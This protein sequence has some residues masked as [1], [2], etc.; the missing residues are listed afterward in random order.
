MRFRKQDGLRAK[1]PGRACTQSG[2]QRWEW[3]FDARRGSGTGIQHLF[4]NLGWSLGLFAC[5][6]FSQKGNEALP[7]VSSQWFNSTHMKS[8]VAGDA[9]VN[10]YQLDSTHLDK[11][12]VE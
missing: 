9:D 11:G 2:V 12:R 8:V 10:P 1:A 3:G 4:Y 6:G 7:A 5:K